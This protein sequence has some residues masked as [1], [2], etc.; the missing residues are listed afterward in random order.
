MQIVVCLFPSL[1]VIHN[2]CLE[3][4][5]YVGVSIT[6]TADAYK[7]GSF[8][9]QSVLY[10]SETFEGNNMQARTRRETV[11]SM[12]CIT[13]LFNRCNIMCIA[14][15]VC[16]YLSL[17]LSVYLYMHLLPFPKE[18]LD[19]CFA[20]NFRISYVARKHWQQRT[21]IPQRHSQKSVT[22]HSGSQ[23]SNITEM[24]RIPDSTP[25]DR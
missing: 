18:K 17:Y 12:I 25:L 1:C 13:A 14:Y 11:H 4:H 5:K 20:L 7:N 3:G 16:I 15:P 21:V 9:T 6:F 22:V 24:H 23:M 19:Y 10:V 2:T 8:L